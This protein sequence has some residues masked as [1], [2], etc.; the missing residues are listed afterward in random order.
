MVEND[1]SEKYTDTTKYWTPNKIDTLK[2]R[3][4][5]KNYQEIVEL[6]NEKIVFNNNP[7][8]AWFPNIWRWFE[9]EYI[10]T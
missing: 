7:V 5:R 2:G 6:N 10:S 3:P 9:R 4:K 1:D 8:N